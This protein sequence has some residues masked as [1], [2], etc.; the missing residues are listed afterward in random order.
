M[1]RIFKW[2]CHEK[3]KKIPNFLKELFHP[4]RP[5]MNNMR[6]C[7]YRTNTAELAQEFADYRPAA[8]NI[9]CVPTSANRRVLRNIA[10]TQVKSHGDF[11]TR[12]TQ[13]TC[14]VKRT[15]FVQLTIA[16]SCRL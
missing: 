6:I 11:R 2:F 5:I 12:E 16:D 3:T 15:F 4:L 9:I 8:K 10:M 1:F 7:H 13:L 14:A